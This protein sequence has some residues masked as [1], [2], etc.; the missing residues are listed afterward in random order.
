MIKVRNDKNATVGR[1]IKRAE[2]K[3]SHEKSEREE[4]VREK[5]V[6]GKQKVTFDI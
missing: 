6:R 5:E 2:D 4:K 3:A 1:D